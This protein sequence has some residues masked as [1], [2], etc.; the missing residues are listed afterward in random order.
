[1]NTF[2]QAVNKHVP[3]LIHAALWLLEDMGVALLKMEFAA[4]TKLVL[5]D[6]FAFNSY[7]ME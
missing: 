6:Q 5:L 1:M 4:Q 2:A 7:I 3:M